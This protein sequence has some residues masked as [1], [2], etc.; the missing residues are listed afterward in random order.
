MRAGET[1]KVRLCADVRVIRCVWRHVHGLRGFEALGLCTYVRLGGRG[2][3]RGQ[4]AGGKGG[5]GRVFG[6]ARG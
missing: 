4:A 6:L 1:E 5:D 2:W 3:G